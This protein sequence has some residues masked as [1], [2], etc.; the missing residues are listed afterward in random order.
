[1]ND[2]DLLQN[3]VRDGSEPAFAE[4]VGRYVDVVYGS[5]RRQVRDAHLAEDVTQAVFIVLAKKA[6]AI[7]PETLPGWLI[8]ATTYASKN[9]LQSQARRQRHERKAAE[10]FST[11]T[12]NAS[13]SEPDIA[14]LLDAALLRLGSLDRTIVTLR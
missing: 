1:M 8:K 9:A 6:A 5:A 3:Y 11:T 10:M 12:A 4:L 2:R 13:G 7:R 14:P